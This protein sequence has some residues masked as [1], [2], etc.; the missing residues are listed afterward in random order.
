MVMLDELES[1]LAALYGDLDS[2]K[3][4][5]ADAGI[6]TTYLEFD[7]PIINVWHRI[8]EQAEKRHKLPDL[9]RVV[10]RDYPQRA[11]LQRIYGAFLYRPFQ[12]RPGGGND[13]EDKPMTSR[14][15]RG[16]EGEYSSRMGERVA[17]LEEKT[18]TLQTTMAD[19]FKGLD[20]RLDDITAAL[21]AR[22]VG[23]AT[24]KRVERIVVGIGIGFAVLVVLLLIVWLRLSNVVNWEALLR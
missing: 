12:D 14:Y 10:I 3:R 17:R 6:P 11:T 13:S 2:A 23:S 16:D 1:E 7:G 9:L 20:G 5:V 21:A 19:G 4:V 22:P 18:A 24:E 15:S 8:I